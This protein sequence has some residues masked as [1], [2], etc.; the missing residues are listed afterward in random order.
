MPLFYP[1]S[2]GDIVYFY[3][4]TR[5]DADNWLWEFGDGT[6]S[7]LKSPVH[8]FDEPGIHEV[9]LSAYSG[10]IVNTIVIRFDTSV[11]KG[12]KSGKGIN[13]AYFYPGGITDVETIKSLSFSVFPNPAK[14]VLNIKSSSEKIKIQIYNILGKLVL[15]KEVV[16]SELDIKSLKSGLYILKVTGNEMSGTV[17][18]I[19]K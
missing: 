4:L 19:K 13:Y 14:D 17:K 5:G 18:F 8:S 12:S 7:T 2:R 10:E 1:D 11:Q 16:T 9:A 3:N 6:S 15:E